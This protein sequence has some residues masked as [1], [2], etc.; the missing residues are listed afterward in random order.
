MGYFKHIKNRFMTLI[1][2]FGVITIFVII[3]YLSSF[4]DKNS[5][6][7]TVSGKAIAVDGDS[8]LINDKRIRIIN[9]DAPEYD[10]TCKDSNNKTYFCGQVAKQR[11]AQLVA[12]NKTICKSKGYDRYKRILATCYVNDKDIGAIMVKEGLAVEYGGYLIEQFSARVKKNGM[13]A[14]KFDSPRDWRK[15]R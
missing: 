6:N 9:I 2:W 1:R 10:Q 14:G 4:L 11:M 8:L 3:A 13:W 7:D 5:T 12:N 15:R